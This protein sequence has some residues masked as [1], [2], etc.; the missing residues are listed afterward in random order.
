MQQSPKIQAWADKWQLAYWD[1]YALCAIIG[2]EFLTRCSNGGKAAAAK[3]TSEERRRRFR[4]IRHKAVPQLIASNRAWR[5]RQKL[6][7][8]GFRVDPTLHPALR[9]LAAQLST[10][11][12]KREALARKALYGQLGI[13]NDE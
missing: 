8:A 6:A 10:A 7:Q 3:L 5:E 4:K 12:Q 2:A 1:A 9:P 13:D 11:L